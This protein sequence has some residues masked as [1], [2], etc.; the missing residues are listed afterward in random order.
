MTSLT[1]Y[2]FQVRIDY[3]GDAY[4]KKFFIDVNPPTKSEEDDGK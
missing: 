3:G 1:S 4:Y 2:K